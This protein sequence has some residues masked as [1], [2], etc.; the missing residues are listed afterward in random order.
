MV[1]P[2]GVARIRERVGPQPAL[3]LI[4]LAQG[5]VKAAAEGDR[6]AVASETWDV[7]ARARLLPAQ[8]EIA[9]AAGDVAR[10]RTAV[11]ELGR[12]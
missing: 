5:N 2:L 12:P 3:A 8:I 6:A 10:A 9:V 4:R 11:D 7:W 1:A